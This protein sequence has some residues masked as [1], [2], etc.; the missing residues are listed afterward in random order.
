MVTIFNLWNLFGIYKMT[1]EEPLGYFSFVLHSHLPWVLNHGVWPHGTDWVNEA[2]AETYV[3]I[4]LELDKLV[5]EGYNPKLTIGLTPVLCEML[6]NEGFKAGFIGYLDTKIS[7]AE[8]DY[9]DFTRNQYQPERIKLT[10]YW[11]EYFLKIK[12]AFVNRYNKNILSGFKTLQDKNLLDIITCGAT[13]GYSP[14]LSRESSINAQ[15]K[16]AVNNYRKHFQRDPTGVWLPEC[17]YRPGYKWKNPVS[18][19]EFERPG[20][21]YFLAKNNLRYFF[22]DTALLMGGLSQ[23]VYAARF[24]LLKELWKQFAK[25]YKDLPTDFEKTPYEPY[26]VS[27]QSA[28][29]PVGFYT[30]DQKTGILVWSGEHGYPGSSEYLDF[31]KKHYPGGLRYWKVTGPK[32]DLGDK[33]LYWVDDVSNKLDENAGHFINVVKDV[34]RDYK[35]K[36]GTPGIITAPYDTELF[37]H[38]WFEGPWWLN[39]VLRWMEDDPEIELTN[40][41]L[42]LEQFPP[43]KVV[44]I[45]EGS[46]GQ[47][48]SHWV[49]LNSWTTWTWEKVYEC[50]QKSEEILS[51][52]HQT[53]DPGMIRILKQLARELLLLQSSDW[54]F[55]ITT[56]SAR[57]YAENRIALHYENFNRL[58]KFASDYGSGVTVPEGEWAFL[59]KI[60]ANDSLFPELEL[61]PFIKK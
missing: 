18:G 24:P 30:R 40:T 5:E 1:Q 9:E 36:T 34:L 32:V 58:Y 54:Q 44:Q 25:Q 3:P 19:E 35:N 20:V 12:D 22:V 29:S 57:D 33:M 59:G 16:I 8:D 39:R 60:E 49:W 48:S 15:F 42:Y 10:M 47:G 2:A 4:L 28:E 26:I 21:E 55:L 6:A 31:H 13:H 37:G 38:W 51:K 11:K 14:L 53:D 61:Y 43:S 56:W 7:A 46:W 23:G 17:A 27:S 50:E 41:R 45:T 52:Y